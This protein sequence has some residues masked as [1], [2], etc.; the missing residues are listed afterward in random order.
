[1]ASICLYNIKNTREINSENENKNS[2]KV[3]CQQREN[4]S[5]FRC[6][7]CHRTIGSDHELNQQHVAC[8]I[9]RM[10]FFTQ[11]T[12]ADDFIRS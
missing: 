5:K 9:K 1:M 11:L 4:Q 3:E 2:S 10:C 7:H 8:K 6:R 12:S